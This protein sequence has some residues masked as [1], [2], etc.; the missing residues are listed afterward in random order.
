MGTGPIFVK[1]RIF[2]P[3]GQNNRKWGLSPLLK[4]YLEMLPMSSLIND[5]LKEKIEYSI[6]PRG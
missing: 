5:F 6:F 1:E 2:S 3:F 4:D